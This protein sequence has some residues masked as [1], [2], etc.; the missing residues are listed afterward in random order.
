LALPTKD[1]WT[2]QRDHELMDLTLTGWMPNEIAMDLKVSTRDVQA[3]FDLLTGLH[4]DVASKKQRRF[5]REA[6]HAAL[7]SLVESDAK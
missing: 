2:L 5:T 4:E 6:V 1:G 7:K 3:R